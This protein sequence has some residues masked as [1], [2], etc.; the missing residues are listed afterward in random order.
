MD[1][2]KIMGILYQQTHRYINTLEPNSVIVEIG[3]E[4]GEGSTDYFSQL[5]EQHKVDFHTVDILDHSI[6]RV[7]QPNVNWHVDDGTAWCQKK[8]PKI[9]K[10]ISVLYL[11]NFDFIFNQKTI[12]DPLWTPELYNRIRGEDWPKKFDLFNLMPEWVKKESL[13]LLQTTEEEIHG[14]IFGRYKTFGFEFNNNM[15][16]QEHFKQLLALYP[17]LA[18]TCTV[19]FDDTFLYNDCWVGKNGPG[20]IFLQVNGFN[21]LV[22]DN[23]G[24]ILQRNS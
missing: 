21:I 24:V 2:S 23:T 6:D 18:D 20:V 9:N 14:G 10:K 15:C 17:Y 1:E 16:Q 22:K 13:E 8:Y 4:R 5:A 3:S 12:H 11:D 7:N 19:V